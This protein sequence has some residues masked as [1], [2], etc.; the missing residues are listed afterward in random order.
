MGH[1]T[2]KASTLYPTLNSTLSRSHADTLPTLNS[3]LSRS[4]ADSGG[5]GEGN[6]GGKRER[7]MGL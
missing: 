7:E 2:F 6:V 4:H 1:N 3:T 5:S